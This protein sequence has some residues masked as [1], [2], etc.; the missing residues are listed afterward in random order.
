MTCVLGLCGSTDQRTARGTIAL[1]LVGI[2]SILVNTFLAV[3]AH[4]S[5]SAAKDGVALERSQLEKVERQ[6]GL[7]QQQLDDVRA[8]ARPADPGVDY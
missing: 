1:A 6:L 3:S 8:A 5:A 7:M 4:R 2:A